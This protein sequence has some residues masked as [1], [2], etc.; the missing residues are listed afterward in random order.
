VRL[1]SPSTPAASPR[2]LPAAISSGVQWSRFRS[3]D[4]Q[5]LKLSDVQLPGGSRF[6]V[7]GLGEE[8]LEFGPELADP[9]GVLWTPSRLTAGHSVEVRA[10]P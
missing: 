9:E 8:P 10:R 6:W 4:R 7:Y 5:R 1:P 3:A 2:D